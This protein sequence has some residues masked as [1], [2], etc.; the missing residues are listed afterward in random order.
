VR[1]TRRAAHAQAPELTSGAF[2]FPGSP[3]RAPLASPKVITT[4]EEVT[5]YELT[6]DHEPSAITLLERH[7]ERI[8]AQTGRCD[9][10]AVARYVET[11]LRIRAR[12]PRPC[13]GCGAEFREPRPLVRCTR[14]RRQRRGKR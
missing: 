3:D 1:R 12:W 5:M 9:Y 10:G 14:C 6:H 11:R 7:A 4:T 13:A 2:S 8:G